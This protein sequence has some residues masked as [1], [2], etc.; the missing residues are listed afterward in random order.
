MAGLVYAQVLL[1]LHVVGT[2][3]M[4]SED[5]PAWGP[6]AAKT[7]CPYYL[8]D[9]RGG[10]ANA[11]FEVG[12]GQKSVLQ[13]EADQNNYHN[14]SKMYLGVGKSCSNEAGASEDCI[15][16]PFGEAFTNSSFFSNGTLKPA[17]DFTTSPT[18]PVA[19]RNVTPPTFTNLNAVLEDFPYRFVGRRCDTANLT[20]RHE[21]AGPNVHPI[22]IHTNSFQYIFIENVSGSMG[23]DVDVWGQV[24]DWHDTIPTSDLYNWTGRYRF[25]RFAGLVIMHC[26]FLRHE[27]FGMMDR[28]WINPNVDGRSM[29]CSKCV[30]VI[31]RESVPGM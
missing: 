29:T 30:G 28:W 13:A 12:V 23:N 18:P 24:G 6:E 17:F 27:D 7:H 21:P 1:Q 10:T 5:A 26:H 14:Q 2:T 19:M 31:G 20:I 8:Q 4:P 22:H 11:A 25:D 9:L 16:M 15:Y 3:V